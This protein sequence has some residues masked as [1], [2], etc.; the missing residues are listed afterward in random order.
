MR[1]LPGEDAFTGRSRSASLADSD[2]TPLASRSQPPQ[3]TYFL[4]D[5]KTM[6]SSQSS[7]SSPS[8][9]FPKPRDTLKS[10]TYGVESLETTISSLAPD[11]DD[12]EER[13]RKARHNWKKNLG[14]PIS[15]NSE[16]DLSEAVSP[17]F[18][19]SAD[20][21]RDASPS[22]Q[23]RLSQATISRPFTPL[24]FGSHAP[25]SLM[26]SPGS[27][28]NSDAGSYLDDI[29][30]QAIVSSGDE[31]REGGQD[32]MD[33]GSAPQL[34]MPS[35]KM[36]SRRPFT[37]KGKNMGRLK[38]L[39]AGDS[40]VGKTSLIKAIVQTC[41]DIVHVDP[42]TPNPISIPEPRR[43]S[44]RTKSRNGHGE[45]QTTSQITEVY[46]STRAYPAWWSDLEESR[47]LR[48][49]K[50]LGDSVLERNL[51]FVD[52]PGYGHKTSCLECITPVVDYIESHLRKATS[53]EN[54]T[55][56]EMISMLSGNGGSQVDLV[57]YVIQHRIK[58]VDLEY[59]RRL[60]PLTNVI[61][62]LAQADNLSSQELASL[63]ENIQSEL[64]GA[65]IR[66]FQ[67][68][69]SPEEAFSQ[70]SAP[71]AVSTTP[72]KD[73]ETM[74]ASLLMSP[75][76]VSPLI[77]SELHTLVSHIFDPSSISWLRHS[78][79]KKFIQWRDSSMAIC[80]PQSLYQPLNPPAV[81]SSHMLTG[82]VGATTSYA[83][84]RIT[85]HTQ[86]E[87]RMAQVRLANW[88][89]DLQR[90]LQN[91][92]ARFD[93]L[94]RSE[95]AVWLTERLGEC[96]QDGTIIPIS[97]ARQRDDGYSGALVNQ[98]TYS[99]RKERDFNMQRGVD[100][101]D[102][103]GLLK[104]NAEMKH[105]GWVAM[106]VISS[107]GILGGFAF[108]M[109]KTWHITEETQIWGL[110]VRDWFESGAIDWR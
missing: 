47:I 101:H 92:R 44:S 14:R 40:G 75:D 97:E 53:L 17:M 55:E 38:V 100:K 33:S 83:L 15:R 12:S 30:S 88:A 89:A 78:A 32:M 26:S 35:I 80:K 42:L 72:S 46:A 90:S 25:A 13:A 77:P 86:R 56:S 94:A 98:S 11:S 91:E 61:P 87:E 82:P 58:P 23:R 63:K 73:H 85:D 103:L 93:A 51:C 3:M 6:E 50:S 70:T 67:F 74:D 41:E 16:E 79:A 2:T 24:S 7:Q 20:I 104:L 69:V 19:S 18:K 49:R 107:F 102:P 81:S 43:K 84:A 9:L 28:R 27:R 57:L 76:Y 4:A 31:E 21:S 71:F 34:V 36:P 45:M 48:R 10:S 54:M 106:K 109:L 37:E 68:A 95:R 64:E 66:S 105:K 60:S 29:A 22:H 108:W 62:L 110:G 8:P 1:P 99:R 59:L 65:N 39:I 5:E 52:T 96:V